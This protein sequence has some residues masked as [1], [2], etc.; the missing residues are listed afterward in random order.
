MLIKQS[1][2]VVSRDVGRVNIWRSTSAYGQSELIQTG[3]QASIVA[4]V[5]VWFG[6]RSG[7]SSLL[8]SLVWSH[9]FAGLADLLALVSGCGPDLPPV[10]RIGQ[11]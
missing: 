2:F 9:S 11:Q 8:C 5:H 6:A 3:T 10:A 7:L 1:S 4:K